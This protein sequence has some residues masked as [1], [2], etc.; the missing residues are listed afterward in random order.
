MIMHN[1]I[2]GSALEKVIYGTPCSQAILQE[3]KRLNAQNVFVMT[4]PELSEKTDEI[5]KIKTSLGNRFAGIYD[6]MTA[7]TPID[8]VLEATQEARHADID[9]LVSVG[10]SSITDAGKVLSICLKH[11]LSYPEQLAE[12]HY[13]VDKNGNFTSPE[14]SGPDIHFIAVPTTLSGAEFTSIAGAKNLK[15]QIKE[16]YY[17]SQLVPNIVILDPMITFQ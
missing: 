6:K 12:F 15:K 10:G 13:S 14:F 5:E 1:T 11:N 17:H 3:A 8:L 9:M 7:H 16:G 4:I 2:Q